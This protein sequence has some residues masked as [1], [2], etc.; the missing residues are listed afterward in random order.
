MNYDF[1][2]AARARATLSQLDSAISPVSIS[3]TKFSAGQNYQRKVFKCH[4]HTQYIYLCVCV[5]VHRISFM[6]HPPPWSRCRVTGG[7][8]QEF[9]MTPVSWLHNLLHLHMAAFV[10]QSAWESTP[11]RGLSDHSESP[12]L[13]PSPSP[14]PLLLLLHPRL[15]QVHLNIQFQLAIPVPDFSFPSLSSL[16]LL[17]LYYFFVFF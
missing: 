13:S 17:L 9:T 6:T 10:P 11:S 2:V 4:T 8:Q 3:A 12:L 16:L 15:Q 5:R 1:E 14:P 7:R